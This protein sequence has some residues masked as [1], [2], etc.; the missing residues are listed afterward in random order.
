MNLKSIW[1]NFLFFC[2]GREY[3]VDLIGNPDSL[4]EPDSSLNGPHSISIASPLR[5]PKFKSI[6]TKEN[7]RDLAK[8]YFLD[9][10]LLNLMFNDVS[11]GIHPFFFLLLFAFGEWKVGICIYFEMLFIIVPFYNYYV[12]VFLE[13]LKLKCLL[14]LKV[15][16]VPLKCKPSGNPSMVHLDYLCSITFHQGL[17]SQNWY[18]C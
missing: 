13:P 2:F 16:A 14:P 6:E 18:R 10:Q 12:I 15:H 8:Q 4:C 7:F 3:L 1:L 9:C 11:A 17:K 5:P